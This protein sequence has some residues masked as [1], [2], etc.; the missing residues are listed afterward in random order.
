MNAIK[1]KGAVPNTV[2]FRKKS[3]CV[4]GEKRNRQLLLGD[5]VRNDLVF[6]AKAG[7]KNH[8]IPKTLYQQ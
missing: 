6:E 2:S 1:F 3:A 4:D 8:T 5:E 7:R